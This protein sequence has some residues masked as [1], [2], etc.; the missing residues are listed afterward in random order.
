MYGVHGRG[1]GCKEEATTD[2]YGQQ[3]RA[4][5]RVPDT[6]GIGVRGTSRNAS[7]GS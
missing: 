2:R 7:R 3:E 6:Y 1:V 5:L 4:I